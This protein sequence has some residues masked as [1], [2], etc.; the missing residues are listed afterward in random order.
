MRPLHGQNL[1]R[2]WEQ[3]SSPARVPALHRAISML[4]FACPETSRA[5]LAALGVS[6][7]DHLLL[8]MREANFGPHVD[9][10]FDCSRCGTALEFTTSTQALLASADA[11][12]CEPVSVETEDGPKTYRL[13]LREASSD[14]LEAALSVADANAERRLLIERCVQ[15]EDEAGHCLLFSLWPAALVS[16]AGEWLEALH[17]ATQMVLHFDCPA[18]AQHD[19]EAFDAAAFVWLEVSDHAQRLLDDVH[20]LAW[21]YGWSEAGILRMNAR[22]RRAYLERA[23]S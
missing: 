18:C 19:T 9:C 23:G 2:A 14:D 4:E 13:T 8:Q 10:R 22:R 5:E 3:G 15:A 1:L 20:A 11:G 21:A 12:A 17:A 6:R 16:C 7:R